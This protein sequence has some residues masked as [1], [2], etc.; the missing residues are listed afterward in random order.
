[1]GDYS[2]AP[3]DRQSQILKESWFYVHVLGRREMDESIDGR[4]RGLQYYFWNIG[5]DN[6]E[7]LRFGLKDTLHTG[8]L[9]LEYYNFLYDFI[10][11][12]KE[13]PKNYRDLLVHIERRRNSSDSISLFIESIYNEQ[14]SFYRRYN[15]FHCFHH[16]QNVNRL[17]VKP[18]ETI[19]NELFTLGKGIVSQFNAH[20]ELL[21]L[22]HKANNLANMRTFYK[23]S[24]LIPMKDNTERMTFCKNQ[25][26]TTANKSICFNN[27]NDYYNLQSIKGIP[28][29][30][31][32]RNEDTCASQPKDLSY[33]AGKDMPFS[34]RGAPSNSK[35]E[36]AGGG[37]NS[38]NSQGSE[39]EVIESEGA[40]KGKKIQRKGKM[41]RFVNE[42]ENEKIEAKPPV[43]NTTKGK[44][45]GQ[46]MMKAYTLFIESF[47][48][49]MINEK[50]SL[51]AAKNKLL[52]RNITNELYAKN[53]KIQDLLRV[54]SEMY[55]ITSFEKMDST[56]EGDFIPSSLG[57]ILQER[58]YKYYTSMIVHTKYYSPSNP[59]QYADEYFQFGAPSKISIL[60]LIDAQVE[61]SDNLPTPKNNS[62]RGT[63]NRANVNRGTVNTRNANKNTNRN[64]T[65]KNRNR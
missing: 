60:N 36:Q 34:R 7:N 6:Y 11:Y 25:T 24:A 43:W 42:N 62:N 12:H 44:Q 17:F 22:G 52:I 5:D 46:N 32:N 56:I 40:P 3:P 58:L 50:N 1:M 18:S 61:A 20:P 37:Q 10:F 65:L 15:F 35:V 30:E 2:G 55:P 51:L 59:S 54:A 23:Q 48:D 9:R 29:P 33:T 57:D 4:I 26:R 27:I 64:T 13:F 31:A 21:N 45:L 8:D 47:Y 41:A 63:E 14:T 39:V 16:N 28:V 49:N 19:L 38:Q 53:I